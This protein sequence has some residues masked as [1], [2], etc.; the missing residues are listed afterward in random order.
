[1][2]YSDPATGSDGGFD[3]WRA[4]ACKVLRKSPVGSLVFAKTD[5]VASMLVT[6]IEVE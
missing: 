5:V 6:R 2:C 1:M 3:Q 4:P